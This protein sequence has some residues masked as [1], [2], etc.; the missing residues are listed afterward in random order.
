MNEKERIKHI[1]D[2]VMEEARAQGND[3]IGKHQEALDEVFETHREEALRQQK[4][5][6]RAE[7]H[8]A[9]RE[10]KTAISKRQLSLKRELNKVKNE[11]KA[12]LFL[13]VKTL[14]LDY[15]K[16]EDY[17]ELLLTYADQVLKY[18]DGEP[19][20]IYV[21]CEDKRAKEFLEEKMSLRVHTSEEDFI[22]GIKAILPS[23][24]ILMDHSFLSSLEKMEE[25]FILEGGGA[26]A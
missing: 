6:I 26:N 9:K 12:E 5:R 16:T 25:E 3:I 21:S 23:R 8:A 18:A 1:Q 19:L 17:K 11:L 2:V 15:M 22:G 4:V 14:L 13:E 10:I 7:Q 20:A 24:N